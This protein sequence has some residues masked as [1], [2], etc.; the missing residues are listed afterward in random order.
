[1]ITYK[2]IKAD[3]LDGIASELQ[4]LVYQGDCEVIHTAREP[5]WSNSIEQQWVS[6]V[7]I[8]PKMQ[9]TLNG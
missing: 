6:L 3:T 7:R 1:M 9:M 8:T 4:N 2:T 5:K